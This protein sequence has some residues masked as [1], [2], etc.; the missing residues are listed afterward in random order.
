M[1]GT[2]I[3]DL[4]AEEGIKGG[5]VEVGV[6]ILVGEAE[7]IFGFVDDESRFL[8]HLAPYALLEG[9]ANIAEASGEVERAFG[10][11]LLARQHEQL[12]LIVDD[13]GCCGS[14]GIRIV[15][16]S[17]V[18]AFLTFE[19]LLVEMLASTHRAVGEPF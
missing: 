1:E 11:F 4:A 18:L 3:A 6:A 16:E 7:E 17:A 15:F 2:Q 13:E 12:P 14:R 8:L 9:L 19:V 5:D 10:W